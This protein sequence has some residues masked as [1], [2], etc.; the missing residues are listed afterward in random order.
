MSIPE[1]YSFQRYLSAKVSVDDRALNRPVWQ[2][3]DQSLL[4]ATPQAPLRVLEVGAGNGAMFERMLAWGLLK[5]AEYTALDADKE[6]IASARQQLPVWADQHGYYVRVT[7]DGSL[8]FTTNERLVSLRLEVVDVFDFIL[9]QTG[10]GTWDLLV[11]HAFLD[12]I[13]IPSALPRLF[14]LC[15]PGALFY[16]TINFDGATLL[17][18]VIDPAFDELIQDIYHRT[19]DERT[20]GGKISGDSRAGRHLFHQIKRA[21]GEILA[22]GA[23]DWVV[24][25]GLQGYPQDEAYFLHHIIH[26][27]HQALAGHAALD[28]Q[29]FERWVSER[30]AQIERGELVYIA[31]QLD[32]VGRVTGK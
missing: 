6:N 24:I 23:S 17:E 30:H 25:P 18:P 5:F 3:L 2:A 13:D 9:S 8:V 14:A 22:A 11:A 26:T 31:H 27:I 19:M 32:Y 1:S 10:V 28:M 20:I 29:R 4:L 7:T 15:K 12:L 16:I 21:G